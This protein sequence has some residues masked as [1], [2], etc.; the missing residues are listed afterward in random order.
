MYGMSVHK[1]SPA[2]SGRSKPHMRAP[3]GTLAW[4][5]SDLQELD[6]ILE[7]LT[8]LFKV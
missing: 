1:G 5:E 6:A 3:R 2:A 4:I 7:D 8:P